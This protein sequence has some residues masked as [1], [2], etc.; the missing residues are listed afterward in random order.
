M[1]S[2][3]LQSLKCSCISNCLLKFATLIFTSS[4]STSAQIVRLC[5]EKRSPAN[6]IL[7]GKVEGKRS[8]G[9]PPSQWLDDVK[10]WTELSLNAMFGRSQRTVWP[11]ES[12]S[13]VLPPTDLI[14][15]DIQDGE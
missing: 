11:G 15:Y 8:R 2:S 12:M 7:Q 5:G 9:R 10:E 13:V 14:V 3:Q 1:V 4:V 6:T